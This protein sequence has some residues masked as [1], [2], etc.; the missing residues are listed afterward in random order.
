M[1]LISRMFVGGELGKDELERF[2]SLSIECQ[3]SLVC[4]LILKRD[5][6]YSD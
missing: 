6:K 1:K 3:S 5:K 2:K 4:E